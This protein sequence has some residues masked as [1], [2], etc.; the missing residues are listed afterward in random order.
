[1]KIEDYV[2]DQIKK[3]FTLDQIKQTLAETAEKVV[4]ENEV[5][6]YNQ[7]ITNDVELMER[8]KQGYVDAETVTDVVLYYLVPQTK[9]EIP[10]VKIKKYKTGFT[11]FLNNEVKYLAADNPEEEYLKE[12][13]MKLF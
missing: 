12:F 9:K 2:L 8:L 13:F 6:D 11:I 4:K 7:N 10:A 1:M 3:G 5:K